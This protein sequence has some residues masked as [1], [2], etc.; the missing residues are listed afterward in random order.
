[1]FPVQQTCD[2]VP[3]KLRLFCP[4]LVGDNVQSEHHEFSICNSI[5]FIIPIQKSYYRIIYPYILLI[6]LQNKG[7]WPCLTSAIRIHLQFCLEYHS[8]MK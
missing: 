3:T 8:K 2:K 6:L 4:D 5:S 1:M 7:R